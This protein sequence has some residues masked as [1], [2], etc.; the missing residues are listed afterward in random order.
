MLY[1]LIVLKS[2][3]AEEVETEQCEYYDPDCKVNLSVKE[4]PMVSLVS[5]A[6]ELETESNLDET[7]NNLY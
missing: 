2:D 6:E 7:E 5:N 3:L 1:R 4:S